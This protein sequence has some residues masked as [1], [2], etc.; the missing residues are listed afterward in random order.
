MLVRVR[1][2]SP[3]PSGYHF[4][5]VQPRGTRKESDLPNGTLYVFGFSSYFLDFDP[6]T[7][8]FGHLARH[9]IKYHSF[10]LRCKSPLGHSR[11][12]VRC[13]SSHPAMFLRVLAGGSMGAWACPYQGGEEDMPLRSEPC[14]W[15]GP[16]V[17][18]PS[19]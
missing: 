10:M 5:H 13:F 3:S 16:L 4:G 7:F 18:G 8:V 2:A 11:T 6:A 1:G 9:V 14:S 19:V 15:G 12:T 17:L